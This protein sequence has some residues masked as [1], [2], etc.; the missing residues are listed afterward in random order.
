MLLVSELK[1]THKERLLTALRRG[2][3]DRLPVTTHHLMQ[4]FLNK[5]FGGK[6]SQEFFEHFDL[7]A[8][9]W[10]VCHKPNVAVEIISILSRESLGFL[11]RDGFGRIAGRFSPKIFPLRTARLRA[12][13]LRRPRAR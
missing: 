12:T 5:Y 6:S 3:P 10:P 7:D 1:M 2:K 8:I 4:S 13:V 11:R 9:T